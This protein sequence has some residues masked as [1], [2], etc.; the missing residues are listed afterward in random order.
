MSISTFTK[1]SD[2]EVLKN[3]MING[4]NASFIGN[5]FFYQ[6]AVETLYSRTVK[7]KLNNKESLYKVVYIKEGVSWKFKCITEFN[8]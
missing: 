3:L 6:N 8:Q 4:L 2:D 7:L 5:G 1:P